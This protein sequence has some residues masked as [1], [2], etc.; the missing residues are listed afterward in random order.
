MKLFAGCIEFDD[1]SLEPII[2]VGRTLE[3]AR[4]DAR[5]AIQGFYLSYADADDPISVYVHEHQ[6]VEGWDEWHTPLHELDGTPWVTIEERELPD[7]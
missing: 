3:E 5:D 1:D 4:A 6:D 7:D 2:I